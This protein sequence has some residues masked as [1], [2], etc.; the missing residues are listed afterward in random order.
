ME[1]LKIN[2]Y[3]QHFEKISIHVFHNFN[4]TCI[5]YLV[6]IDHEG[7]QTYRHTVHCPNPSEY[8][9]HTANHRGFC[10]NKATNVSHVY[11]QSYLQY[12]WTLLNCKIEEDKTQRY[13]N[14]NQVWYGPMFQKKD[15]CRTVPSWQV[16]VKKL[17]WVDLKIT[18]SHGILY[19]CFDSHYWPEE[20]LT[21][22]YLTCYHSTWLWPWHLDKTWFKVTIHLLPTCIFYLD[23]WSR[24]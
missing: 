11:Y 5:I 2:L 21:E 20:L 6:H 18:D 15:T 7:W 17:S 4:G 24:N 22:S 10:W 12:T 14:F 9:V 3:I 13:C 1:H 16:L 23:I 8:P 19:S